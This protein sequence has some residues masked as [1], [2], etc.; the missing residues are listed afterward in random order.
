M[1][2][3]KKYPLAVLKRDNSGHMV[4]RH[5]GEVRLPKTG[6]PEGTDKTGSSSSL[7]LNAA[8]LCYTSVKRKASSP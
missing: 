1:H 5:A 6:P 7:S 8:G 3:F 2:I 4:L